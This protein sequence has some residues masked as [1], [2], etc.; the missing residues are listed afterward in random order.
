MH[1]FDSNDVVI[2]PIHAILEAPSSETEL[3]SFVENPLAHMKELD[4]EEA[5]K[6]FIDLNGLWVRG[7]VFIRP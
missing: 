3:K 6:D 1:F 5:I 2:L 4:K 7:D